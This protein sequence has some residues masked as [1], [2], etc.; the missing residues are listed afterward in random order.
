[1]SRRPV[2]PKPGP[3]KTRATGEDTTGVGRARTAWRQPAVILGMMMLTYIITYTVLD[4][5]LYRYYL[6][7]NFDL[8]IFTQAV[9]GLLHGRLYSSIRGMVWLGDHSS[10]ILFLIAPIYAV[11]RHP[12]TLLV[13][14]SAAQALGALPMFALAQRELDQTRVAY[15]LAGAYL[16]QPALGYA[17]L[18][19]FHPE[20]LATAP[21]LAAFYYLRCGRPQP[22]LLWAGVALLCRED[23]ALVVTMMA[24]YALTFSRPGRGRLALALGVLAAASALLTWGVLR[25]AFST[26]EANYASMYR[27]WGPTMGSALA[28]MLRDPV[29]VALRLFSTPGAPRDTLI[30]QQ[31]HL[32]LFLPLGLLPLFS[33]VTLLIAWPVFAEHL[34]SGRLAQHTILCQYTALQVPFVS[35][36]AVMGAR[37]LIVAL[38]SGRASKGPRQ[39][40]AARPQSVALDARTTNA[41]AL[42][43]VATSIGC[44]L[45]FGPLSSGKFFITGTRGR[46]LPTAE[47]RTMAAYRDSL[48]ARVP[49]R[50]AVVASFDL[51]PRFASRDS[52]H[53]LHHVLGGTY[54][55]SSR[56]FPTPQGVSAVVADLSESNVLGAV[57][58]ASALRFLEMV[59]VNQLVPVAAYGDL[60]LWLRGAGDSVDLVRPAA[61]AREPSP[62]R[63]DRQLAFIDGALTDTLGQPGG[64]VGL[65]TY[66]QRTSAIDRF[67]QVRLDCVDRAGRSR[68]SHDRDLGYVLWPPHLWGINRT[69]RENYHLVLNGDLPPGDY[70][71]V[72]RLL[73][74]GPGPPELSAADDP[75]RYSADRGIDLGHLR[76]EK[77]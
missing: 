6:Y 48:L 26:G 33:P 4:A 28:N 24:L 38:G 68:A 13:V 77:P 19:E 36:A 21:L 45:W 16:L 18:Y 76:V 66:W 65:S 8:A 51:L 56:P 41:V 30:K 42:W 40:R 49:T 1:M 72:L 15:V 50:G 69:V 63:F 25:P 52:V 60:I 10:L 3:V 53:S 23:V 61:P 22:T 29:G 11:A 14:Q 57:S 39:K 27:D 47:E 55:L 34:L 44:Q 2:G 9:D 70:R 7:T 74:R 62:I 71:V 17:N 31:F 67:F 73:E 35:A 59:R 58:P 20:L 43:A 75:T 5:I 32:T 46:H 12:L 64:T 37:N 54:T